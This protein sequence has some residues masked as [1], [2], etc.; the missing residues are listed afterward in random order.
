MTAPAAVLKR[1]I[2]KTSRLAE[3]TSQR[4]LVNTTVHA[5]DDW[6][7]VV[8]KELLD[9]ALG[10]TNESRKADFELEKI[11]QR[12]MNN[13]AL[14]T[15]GGGSALQA[16]LERTMASK[17]SKTVL[18]IGNKGV[19]KST[20]IDRFFEQGLPRAIR[21]KCVVAR[22]DLQDYHVD[23][24]GIVSWLILQ[25]RDKLE[26]SVCSSDPPTYDCRECSSRNTS[27]SQSVRASTSTRRIGSNSKIN[28]ACTWKS[29][30]R[31]TRTNMSDVYSIGHCGATADC[32]WW[33]RTSP[34]S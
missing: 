33:R 34:K 29:A 21:E 13:I 32:C 23:P 18:L 3:F 10:E 24:K 28:L 8:V 9:N 14:I 7:L 17:R 1:N 2:F 6:P 31:R 15:T 16:E 27:A 5:T 20:F 30:A 12:V 11:I 19:G 25:L 26:I 22:V 4:E